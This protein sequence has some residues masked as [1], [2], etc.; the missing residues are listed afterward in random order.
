MKLKSDFHQQM[1]GQAEH[2]IQSLEYILRDCIIDFKGSWDLHLNLV[3]LLEKIVFIYPY[4]CLIMKL[5]T[6][7][8]VGLMFCGLGLR[9]L[10]FLVSILSKRP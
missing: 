2:T 5:C 1:D 10:R 6:V 8:G 7:E 9:S 3:E 4:L